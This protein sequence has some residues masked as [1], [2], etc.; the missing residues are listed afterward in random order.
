MTRTKKYKGISTKPFKHPGTQNDVFMGEQK[1][2]F[3]NNERN[4]I[5]NERL[6]FKRKINQDKINIIFDY[7]DNVFSLRGDWDRSYKVVKLFFPVIVSKDKC[8]K[9]EELVNKAFESTFLV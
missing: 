3:V 2:K 4:R 8:K 7:S 5:K 1:A 9:F 6:A